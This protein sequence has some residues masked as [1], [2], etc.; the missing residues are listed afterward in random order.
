MACEIPALPLWYTVRSQS[1]SQSWLS[2]DQGIG[3]PHISRISTDMFSVFMSFKL[4]NQQKSNQ[5]LAIKPNNENMLDGREKVSWSKCVLLL[6]TEKNVFFQKLHSL[7][8]TFSAGW[9]VNLYLILDTKL[10][11]IECLHGLKMPTRCSSELRPFITLT[12][13][14]GWVQ[15]R[16][17]LR[18]LLLGSHYSMWATV[19]CVAP[20]FVCSWGTVMSFCSAT[21]LSFRGSSSF[22]LW[23]NCFVLC[24]AVVA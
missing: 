16:G 9:T 2:V 6:M 17:M 1:T 18:S 3:H 4:Q 21:L 20:S 24:S 12:F 10:K 8:F 13:S 7:K 14:L 15:C 19:L 11:W 23:L 22:W 5:I